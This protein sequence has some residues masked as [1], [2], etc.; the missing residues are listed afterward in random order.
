MLCLFLVR[1]IF[2][3]NYILQVIK[4]IIIVT[5][6]GTY[7]SFAFFMKACYTTNFAEVSTFGYNSKNK[8]KKEGQQNFVTFVI[9]LSVT[10]APT[11][12]CTWTSC[13]FEVVKIKVLH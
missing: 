1:A 2:E 3:F 7:T 6:R 13:C 8:T 10:M 12:Q 5:L 9:T 4:L 11:Q